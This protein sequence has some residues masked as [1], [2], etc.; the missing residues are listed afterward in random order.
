MIVRNTNYNTTL[1]LNTLTQQQSSVFDAYNKINNNEKF[2]NI[3]ENPIDSTAVIN[4]NN[5]LQKLTDYA[6]NISAATAQ[7][8]IQDE[9]FSTIVAKMQRINDLTI[10]AANGA[11]GTDGIEACKNE[12]KEL[13]ETI[14]SL[15]NT[16]YNGIYIFGGANTSTPPYKLEADGSIVYS[17]TPAADPSFQRKLEIAE[18]VTVNLNAAGDSVFGNYNAGD[19]TATPPVPPSGDG[20]FKVLG[21]LEAALNLDPPDGDKIRAQIDN[22]QSSIKN[23]SEIQSIYSASISKMTMTKTNIDDT[24]LVLKSQKQSLQEIDQTTAISEFIKQNYAYQAS[25]QV[26]MQMQNQS[27]MNYM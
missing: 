12:I 2:S 4:I 7:I 14:V 9:T 17:G 24:T 19:P 13:K 6:K 25:M 23:V 22:I 11:S 20:L 3:S 26:F 1:M 5:Q 15:A 8:N 21:D 27:L 16:Q 10:E 18:G